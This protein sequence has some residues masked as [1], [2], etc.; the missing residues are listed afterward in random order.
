MT[1]YAE[2]TNGI[3]GERPQLIEGTGRD[4]LIAMIHRLRGELT[5]AKQEA[6]A[7]RVT[8]TAAERERTTTREM[9]AVV[10]EHCSQ[11]LNEL[12]QYR[13]GDHDALVKSIARARGLH[14]K[15]SAFV[16]LVDEMGELS[17][18]MRDEGLERTHEELLDVATVAYRMYLGEC[19]LPIV[20]SVK[21]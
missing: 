9:H 4:E 13:G 18:A 17:R 1:T 14:P 12:R 3:T 5:V 7:A 16:D 10:Q 2:T 19:R 21:P 8:A 6:E 11:Q 20:E 15:G